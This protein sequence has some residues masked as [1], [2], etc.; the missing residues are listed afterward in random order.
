[1][2]LFRP[3]LQLAK[4]S[5]PSRERHIPFLKANGKLLKNRGAFIKKSA[6]MDDDKGET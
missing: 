6:F 2:V 4:I 5:C 1:M 3:S